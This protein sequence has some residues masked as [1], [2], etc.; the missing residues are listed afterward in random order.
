MRFAKYI[1]F[2]AFFSSNLYGRDCLKEAWN[3]HVGMKLTYSINDLMDKY[4]AQKESLSVCDEKQKNEIWDSEQKALIE[5]YVELKKDF[6]RKGD[7]SSEILDFGY[8]IDE[9]H[10]S[11]QE[12]CVKLDQKVTEEVSCYLPHSYLAKLKTTDFSKTKFNKI[13]K[14]TLPT[15]YKLYKSCRRTYE[16][17]ANSTQR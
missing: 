10:L 4:E 2:L 17:S 7:I 12:L 15:L 5:G 1:I 3:F 16:A 11:P 13:C 8:P 14:Q 9:K 6:A